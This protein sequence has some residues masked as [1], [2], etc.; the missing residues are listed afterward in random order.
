MPKPKKEP[1][2]TDA[3]WAEIIAEYAKADDEAERLHQ[4]IRDAETRYRLADEAR[5]EVARRRNRM[6]ALEQGR[7]VNSLHKMLDMSRTW[8]THLRD[9]Y[10]ADE[11]LGA[12]DAAWQAKLD[13]WHAEASDI[14]AAR[15]LPLHVEWS[16][17]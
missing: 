14:D 7:S 5:A 13:R 11:R 15:S 3:Q 17:Q 10:M 6:L 2:Y 9:A 8:I 4:A 1:T 12:A 16:T